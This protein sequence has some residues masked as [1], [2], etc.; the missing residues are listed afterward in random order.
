MIKLFLNE[1]EFL[2]LHERDFKLIIK[3]KNIDNLRRD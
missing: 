2:P 1:T 3:N